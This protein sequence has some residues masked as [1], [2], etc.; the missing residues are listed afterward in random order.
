[1]AFSSEEERWLRAHL[2][3]GVISPSLILLALCCLLGDLKL[4]KKGVMIL[5]VC[6]GG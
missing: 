2:V 1:M 4:F 3:V 5:S 6:L